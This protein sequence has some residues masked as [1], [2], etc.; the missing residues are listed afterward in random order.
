MV[1]SV[2]LLGALRVYSAWVMGPPAR[3]LGP[4][5]LMLKA[6]R[7]GVIHAAINVAIHAATGA[8]PQADRGGFVR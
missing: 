2:V 6:M 5:H 8:E 4:I 1:S 3:T 7:Y